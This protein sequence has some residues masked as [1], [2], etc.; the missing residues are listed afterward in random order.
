MKT[1]AIIHCAAKTPLSKTGIKRKIIYKENTKITKNLI[2]FSNEN[3]VKKLIFLSSV[4]VY[5]LIKKMISDNIPVY[6]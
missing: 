5:G 1:D 6:L 2:K 4:N 3:N